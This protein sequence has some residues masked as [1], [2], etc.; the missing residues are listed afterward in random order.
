MYEGSKFV[1]Y[2]DGKGGKVFWRCAH[3]RKC[4]AG[5]TTADDVLDAVRDTHIHMRGGML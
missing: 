4:P 5:M 1:K 3:S 2:R